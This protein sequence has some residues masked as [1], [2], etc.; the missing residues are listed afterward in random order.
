MSQGGPSYLAL[1]SYGSPLRKPVVGWLIVAGL[2][3]LLAFGLVQVAG[4]F[5]TGRPGAVAILLQALLIAGLISLV[6]IAVLRWLDRREP[7]PWFMY[8]LAIAW[9]G[10]IATGVSATVNVRAMAAFGW[11]PAVI[12]TGPIIEETAKGL[13]LILLLVLLR[14]EFDGPRDGFIYGVLI[15]LGFDWLETA[16]YIAR[17]FDPGIPSPWLMQIASRYALVGFSGHGLYTG[18]F[19]TFVGFALLYRSR[20]KQFAI[21]LLG[22]L[23]AICNHIGWN[24]AGGFLTFVTLQF[25]A[26]LF[27]FSE[28]ELDSLDSLPLWMAWTAS[29]FAALTVNFLG[30][31]L[32]VVGLWRSGKWEQRTMVE[33]LGS[34][35]GTPV[36]TSAEFAAIQA[37]GEPPGD[38]HGRAIFQAQCNLAKRKAFLTLRD[39]PVETDPV[40]VAWRAEA[41]ALHQAGPNGPMAAPS[42]V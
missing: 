17:G 32:I 10:L 27:G 15:G 14:S 19:G 31:V 30:Y 38:R 34:E 23:L 25:L 41:T 33:Q 2:L 6:P 40:V 3:L 18:L 42:P 12:I 26:T 5:L 13:G 21:G 9:G 16:V 35:L 1:A 22:Y 7:E 39:Q 28:G 8:A 4:F 37:T 29:L 20:V 11:L 36:V 24:A